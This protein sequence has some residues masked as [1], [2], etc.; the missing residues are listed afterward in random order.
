MTAATIYLWLALVGGGTVGPYSVV[1]CEAWAAWINRGWLAPSGIFP[2]VGEREVR[3][4]YCAEKG[5]SS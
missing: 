1:D 4:A 5:T 2:A 3:V